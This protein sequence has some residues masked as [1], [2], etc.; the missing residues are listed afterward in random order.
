MTVCIAHVI[1]HTFVLY[2]ILFPSTYIRNLLDSS[3]LNRIK[4]QQ[5]I[6]YMAFDTH[7]LVTVDNDVTLMRCDYRI[8]FL[9][10]SFL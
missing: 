4:R 6:Q 3:R 9:V 10:G 5:Y 2:T 1:L 7:S 8:E